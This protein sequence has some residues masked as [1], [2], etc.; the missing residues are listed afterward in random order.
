M[1]NPVVVRPPP[2]AKTQQLHQDASDVDSKWHAW[3]CKM[4]DTLPTEPKYDWQT[5]YVPNQTGCKPSQ[6]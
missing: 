4:T 3:M 1:K 5:D 6:I 2:P